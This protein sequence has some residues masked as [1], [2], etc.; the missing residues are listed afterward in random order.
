[1]KALFYRLVLLLRELQDIHLEEN[2]KMIPDI[3]Y[4]WFF[5]APTY[6]LFGLNLIIYAP[7]IS[8]VSLVKYQTV[9][10]FIIYL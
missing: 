4:I 7:F 9:S 8:C 2:I 1:M 10:I 3:C 6:Y 5:F